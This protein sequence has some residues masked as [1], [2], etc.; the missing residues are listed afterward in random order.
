M[1]S[2]FWWQWEP[3]LILFYLSLLIS[4]LSVWI[5]W[6]NVRAS[7]SDLVLTPCFLLRCMDLR[8]IHQRSN[9][10]RQT[11]WWWW[12]ISLLRV[13]IHLSHLYSTFRMQSVFVLIYLFDGQLVWQVKMLWGCVMVK[14]KLMSKLVVSELPWLEKSESRAAWTFWTS[15]TAIPVPSFP[16]FR[17]LP[18]PTS[19]LQE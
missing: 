7:V 18:S 5:L 15:T 1:S 16:L 13:I 12:Q 14:L 19:L 4:F 3:R 8:L 11:V 17:V 6:L 10:L 2:V 9:W